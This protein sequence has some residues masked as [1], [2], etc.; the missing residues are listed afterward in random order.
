MK[1]T[2]DSNNVEVEEFAKARGIDSEPYLL[3]EYHRT[4]KSEM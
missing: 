3:V 2:K 1:Y 4:C